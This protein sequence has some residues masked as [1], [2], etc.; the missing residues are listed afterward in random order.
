MPCSQRFC[1]FCLFCMISLVLILGGL[2]VL[3]NLDTC[4]RLLSNILLLLIKKTKWTEEQSQ[5]TLVPDKSQSKTWW[6]ELWLTTSSGSKYDSQVHLY[7]LK[8]ES[9]LTWHSWWVLKVEI[10]VMS[11]ILFWLTIDVLEYVNSEYIS[12]YTSFTRILLN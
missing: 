12:S 3:R 4:L 2:L 5:L 7:K 1:D 9:K 10:Y 11:Q 8:H 6:N